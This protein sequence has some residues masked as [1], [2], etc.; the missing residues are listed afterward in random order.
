MNR[1]SNIM[2]LAA[3]ASCCGCPLVLNSLM[4]ITVENH[5]GDRLEVLCVAIAEAGGG[6]HCANDVESGAAV[7]FLFPGTDTSGVTVRARSARGSRCAV[8][9]LY[10]MH[11]L[12]LELTSTDVAWLEDG[13][14]VRRV[15]WGECSP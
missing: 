9:G 7:R 5:A 14:A 3:L 13:A 11:S 12:R 4:L 6:E 1:R 8:L 15:Q 2:L 10:A